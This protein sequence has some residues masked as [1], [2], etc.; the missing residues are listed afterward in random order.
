MPE[1]TDLPPLERALR[2][3]ERAL[4]DYYGESDPSS[5]LL[6]ANA[7]AVRKQLADLAAAGIHLVTEGQAVLGGRVVEL[8]HEDNVLDDDPDSPTCGEF[9]DLYRQQHTDSEEG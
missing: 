9:I 3:M 6:E 5:A 7:A 4:L 8:E 1:P 2:V